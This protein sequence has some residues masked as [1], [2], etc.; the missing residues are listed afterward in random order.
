MYTLRCTQQ[1]L[2]RIH[3]T[4]PEIGAEPTTA[5]GNWYVN[6]LNV[7]RLRLLLCTSERTLLT[8]LV[9]A[10]NLAAFPARLTDSIGR[11]LISL[12]ILADQVAREQREM[13]W[14]QFGRTASRTV[15]GSMVDF[16]FL[17][18]T[19][20][21]DEGADAD[22][23]QAGLFVSRAPCRPIQY[24]SPD[25]FTREVFAEAMDKF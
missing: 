23:D 9:P 11:T 15:L 14:H 25:R 8:V 1:L 5:L 6:T 3:H 20:I 7:G 10:R 12:D 2:G 18:E 13:T 16:A 21:R 4:L 19:Y 17:A 22:L 24:K